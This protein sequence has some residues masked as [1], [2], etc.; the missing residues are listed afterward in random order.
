MNKSELINAVASKTALTKTKA[1]EVID[2]ILES[3]KETLSSGDKVTLVGFGTFGVTKRNARKGHNPKTGASIDIP[4]KTVA[5]F[6]AGTSLS[7]S[8]NK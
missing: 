6:K 5:R 3:I 4:E 2:T 8:V 7:E 1:S